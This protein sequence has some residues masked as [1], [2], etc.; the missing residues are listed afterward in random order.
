MSIV[1]LCPYDINGEHCK[2]EIILWRTYFS[3]CKNC[4]RVI[5][6]R[7]VEMT[8]EE[9]AEE[10]YYKTYPTTLNIGEEERKKTV[11]DIFL[12]GLKVGREI[13]NEY[14]KSNA[15]TSMKEQGL[16][17][18]GKWHK[19]ADGDLPIDGRI[20]CDQE[21]NNVNYVKRLN[22]WFYRHRTCEA[23]VISWCELPKYMKN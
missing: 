13:E 14:V 18:F 15:F 6:K 1:K 4:N 20:V 7:D 17:P 21:G 5:L 10:Y 3:K 11:M 8:D 22:K 2:Y 16:F 9:K 19:V 23:D 12:A